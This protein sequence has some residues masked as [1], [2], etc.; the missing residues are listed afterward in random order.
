VQYDGFW[1]LPPSSVGLLMMKAALRQSWGLGTATS[2]GH[3]GL[4][5]QAA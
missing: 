1:E 4:M 2:P 5:A 3:E